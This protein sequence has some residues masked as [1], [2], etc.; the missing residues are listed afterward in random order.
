MTCARRQLVAE[1]EAATGGRVVVIAGAL[2]L[3]MGRQTVHG[4]ARTGDHAGD[5]R[6]LGV[7]WC[8]YVV[9]QAVARRVEEC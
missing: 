6:R 9:G 8:A 4:V 5:V 7:G 1:V 3:V 2:A